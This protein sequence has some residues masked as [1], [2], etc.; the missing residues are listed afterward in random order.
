MQGATSEAK[1]REGIV[2]GER[3]TSDANLDISSYEVHRSSS[4]NSEFLWHFPT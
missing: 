2:Y 1:I 3:R 4:N